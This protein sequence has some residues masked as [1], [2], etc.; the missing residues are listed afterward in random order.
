MSMT[1]LGLS[2]EVIIAKIRSVSGSDGLNFDTSV[3]GLKSLKEAKVSDYVVK[4]MINPA[5]PPTVVVSGAPMTPD[6]NLPPPEVGVYWK[7]GP[8]FSLVQG[9]TL[10][11]QRREAARRASLPTESAPNIG[12]PLWKARLPRIS[13]RIGA[14]FSISM[15]PTAT[16]PQTT[17]CSA[18]R[19][20]AITGNFKWEVSAG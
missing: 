6:P 13:S 17:F 20:K 15:F 9:R 7:D 5:L 18:S 19:R 1:S 14:L 3:D 4:A 12:M 11:H 10:T 8:A 16:R 2:D